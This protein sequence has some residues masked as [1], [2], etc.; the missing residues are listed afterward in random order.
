[1]IGYLQL[2]RDR[3]R[4][5]LGIIFFDKKTPLGLQGDISHI[6]VIRWDAKIGDSFAS[7]FFFRELK[8]LPNKFITVITSPALAPL[9]REEFGVDHVIEVTKRPS[10][11]TL[12]DIALSIPHVD[13]AIHLTEGMKMKDLYFLYKLSPTNIAS[14]DDNVARVNIKLSD[15]TKG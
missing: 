1:M 3:I 15:T 4:R 6:L 7:S 10:Y 11:K 9:Y 13:L 12:C 8:K 5:A 2:L 14:L